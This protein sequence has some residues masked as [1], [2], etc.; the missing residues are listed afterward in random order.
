[1]ITTVLYILYALL[2]LSALV[3][4][5]ELGHYISG[6]ALGFS[7]LEFSIGMGPRLLKFEKNG[8]LYS[9]KAFPIG[10]SC[11][12][13]GEDEAAIGARDFNALAP[14]R[15]AITLAS[16]AICNILFAF[17]LTI[18]LLTTYGDWD[19]SKNFVG[20]V[21]PGSSAQAAGMMEGDL[22]LSIN[23]KQIRRDDQIRTFLDKA[24]DGSAEIKVER[25]GAVVVLHLTEL[26]NAEEGRNMMGVIMDYS[27]H[28]KVR[29]SFF[30]AVGE[31]ARFVTGMIGEMFDFLKQLVMG[32]ISAGDM[33]GP[34]GIVDLFVTFAPEGFEVVL[35]IAVLL[36]VNLGFI[37]LLP[38]PALDGGRLV[39][40]A[41]EGI[42]KK[43]VPEEIE[44]RIH[45]T[46]LM[47][48]FGLII[49]I[50]IM[51]ISRCIR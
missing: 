17:I 45:A 10:G 33:A 29:Y 19:T 15:R 9:L 46:G 8:I 36:S 20:E 22:L 2:V 27:A 5:H 6:R 50:T 41:I 37:N 47:L 24:K 4:V 35:R 7:V 30:G 14:W 40:V 11:R 12:F 23:G 38:L 1:M 18:I 48:L 13:A 3:T 49:F 51:D 32:R 43:R 31:S 21:N 16:G 42:F 26:F 34:V 28:E 25:G 44:G 39:F